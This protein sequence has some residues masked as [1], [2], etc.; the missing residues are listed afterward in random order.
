MHVMIASAHGVVFVHERTP[1][2]TTKTFC[3]IF[4]RFVRPRETKTDIQTD[5][6]RDRDQEIDR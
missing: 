2:V 6:E 4:G 3:Q 5:R 1:N